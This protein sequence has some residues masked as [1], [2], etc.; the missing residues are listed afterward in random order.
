MNGQL[1]ALALLSAITSPTAIAAV[2]V[3]LSRPNAVAL[4]SAYVIGSFAA[5][6]AVGLGIVE[7]LRDSD[8]FS[9]SERAG[10]PIVHI[11]AGVVILVVSLWLRSD[12]SGPVR[13]KAA[14][15]RAARKARHADPN[16]KPSRTSRM[17]AAGTTPVLGALGVAMHLPGMLYLVALADISHESLD[18]AATVGVLALFN[19]IMLAPIELP[20][21]AFAFAPHRTQDALDRMDAYVR[22]HET[23]VL[24]LG[25]LLAAGY[26]I[27]SGVA[28]LLG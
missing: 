1:L 25:A 9:P 11:V 27:V 20:L 24:W 12:H 23:R 15:M 16:R 21:V 10:N 8:A 6:M 3:I 13:R 26:L 18:T 2:L 5:S 28:G 17:L 7:L 22:T 14:E 4:L 19:L